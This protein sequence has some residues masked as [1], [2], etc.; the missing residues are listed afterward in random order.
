[1]F[2]TVTEVT[3][4]WPGAE[5]GGDELPLVELVCTVHEERKNIDMRSD[6]KKRYEIPLSY[7]LA[8]WVTLKSRLIIL[9]APFIRSGIVWQTLDIFFI[10]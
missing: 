1:L 7:L 8:K 2:E 3:V 9:K 6:I 5:P 4:A 10:I